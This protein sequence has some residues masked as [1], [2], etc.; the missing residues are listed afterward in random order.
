MINFKFETYRKKGHKAILISSNN[1]HIRTDSGNK[2]DWAKQLESPKPIK[3]CNWAMAV[4]FDGMKGKPLGDDMNGLALKFDKNGLEELANIPLFKPKSIIFIVQGIT[5]ITPV[6]EHLYFYFD[7]F[8]F[9]VVL[10]ALFGECCLND[11]ELCAD[12]VDVPPPKFAPVNEPNDGDVPLALLVKKGFKKGKRAA[13]AA[14]AA[15]FSALF[16]DEDLLPPL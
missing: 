15:A 13:A 6:T 8:S 3:A 10:A 11:G 4:K 7:D 1:I 9:D 16:D 12:D 2:V 5:E 14:A